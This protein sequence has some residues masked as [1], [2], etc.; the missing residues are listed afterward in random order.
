MI[1]ENIKNL[2]LQNN[3]TQEEFAARLGVSRSVIANLEYN[4]L[5]EPEKKMPLFRLISERFNVPVEWLLS[6]DPGPLPPMEE[7]HR[8]D[9]AL[10]QLA[11]DPVVRSFL[12][13]WA[14]RTEAERKVLLAAMDDFIDKLRQNRG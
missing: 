10:G 2:R 6:D 3:M 14:D 12:A 11:D 7:Q 4:R 5:S 9:M 13:F 8:Q 1:A